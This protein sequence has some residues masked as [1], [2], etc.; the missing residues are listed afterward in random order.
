MD[1]S[2]SDSLKKI[3]LIESQQIN[4]LTTAPIKAA[5]KGLGRFIPGLGLAAGAYDA[6]GRAKQGDWTGAALSGLGG[7]A[8]L[9]PGVGT[10]ASLG[11]AGIQ[12]GRD[13]ARTGSWMPDDA[14]TAAAVSRDKAA[15]ATP[16]TSNISAPATPALQPSKQMMPGKDPKVLSLQQKLIAKGAKI[17]ADGIMGPHTQAAMKQFPDVQLASK[18][19]K[20]KGTIMSESE[21]ISALRA[22]LEQIDNQQVNEGPLGKAV[23]GLGQKAASFM[24]G[25]GKGVANPK[26]T[27]LPNIAKSTSPTARGARTGAAIATNPGKVAGA[28]GAAGLGAGYFAGQPPAGGLTPAEIKELNQLAASLENSTDP[29]D[30][31]LLG[32]YNSTINRIQK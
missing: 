2:I 30:I 29:I 12:A 15:G 25:V 11:I 16:P 17:K 5:A 20:N 28:A 8:S 19:N 4:E 26:M 24:G 9:I 10:A 32:Q 27:N 1:T 22:R 14:E 7:A 13:K 6:Y 23:M 18:I 21:K 31:E 3:R